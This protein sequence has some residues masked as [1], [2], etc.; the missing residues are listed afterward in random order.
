MKPKITCPY[1]EQ[2]AAEVWLIIH[3]PGCPLG[4]ESEETDDT[5]EEEEEQT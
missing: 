4:A 2:Q 3:E 5:E 1:C